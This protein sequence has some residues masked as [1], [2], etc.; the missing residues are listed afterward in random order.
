VLRN[1]AAKQLYFLAPFD[2]QDVDGKRLDVFGLLERAAQDRDPAIAR[3]AQIELRD[4][5]RP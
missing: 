1:V 5:E 4:L 3:Q 2:G